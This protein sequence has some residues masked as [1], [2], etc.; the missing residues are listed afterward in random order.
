MRKDYETVNNLLIFKTKELTQYSNEIIEL[1]KEKNLKLK[2]INSYQMEIKKITNKLQK[3]EKEIKESQKLIQHYLK[4][5]SWI[6][7]EKQ[8]FGH[9]NTDFDFKAHDMKSATHRLGE[10]KADQVKSQAY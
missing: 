2:E 5:Y 7:K 3:W 10:L 8:Y 9:P 6:S 1:E 4:E